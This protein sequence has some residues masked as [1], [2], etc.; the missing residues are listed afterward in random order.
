MAI[1][2]KFSL[3]KKLLTVNE[4]ANYLHLQPRTVT[5]WLRTGKLNGARIGKEWRVH[6]LDF[7]KYLQSHKTRNLKTDIALIKVASSEVWILGINALGPLHQGLEDI[8][9]QIK[10]GVKVRV[11]LL[12]PESE[13]FKERENDEECHD[14]AI[15]G[16]LQ[17]EYNAALAICRDI[18]N[19]YIHHIKKY[20]PKILG[21]LEIRCH[22]DYPTEAMVIIDP[23]ADGVCN[24]NKYPPKIRTRGLKGGHLQFTRSSKTATQ[25][26]EC[27]KKYE[28]L[29]DSGKEI[30][31]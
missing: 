23:H 12:D 24:V 9:E 8:R 7:Q 2:Y 16:R 20:Q 22:R 17:S 5:Y 4:I 29:W 15:A 28:R 3:N 31:R 13:A 26:E 14:D 30:T 11:L 6:P 18:Q 27:T 21:S 10:N 19:F 1:T 25:F